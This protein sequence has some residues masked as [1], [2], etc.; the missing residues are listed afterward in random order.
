M[1]ATLYSLASDDAHSG[2]C[3]RVEHLARPALLE[4][5]TAVRKAIK[6]I[7]VIDWGGGR[8]AAGNR[9]AARYLSGGTQMWQNRE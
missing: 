2:A 4:G 3:S 7:E 5:S 8:A 1:C 6:G 9:C